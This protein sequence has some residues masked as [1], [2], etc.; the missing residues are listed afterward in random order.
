MY[1]NKIE[2]IIKNPYQVYN[3][4]DF[5]EYNCARLILS[6]AEQV[7]YRASP[8][9]RERDVEKKDILSILRATNILYPYQLAIEFAENDSD[10]SR[11]DAVL[12][13]IETRE[14]MKKDPL[15]NIS[16]QYYAFKMYPSDVRRR[17]VANILYANLDD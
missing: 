7:F 9:A 3:A 11:F 1:S 5:S 13:E 12:D 10:N 17:V 14:I 8:H 4:E 16:E 15:S 2:K 6:L